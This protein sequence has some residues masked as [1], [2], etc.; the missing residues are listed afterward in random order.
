MLT[1]VK[2]FLRWLMAPALYA[3]WIGTV[4]LTIFKRVEW[5][6][7]LLIAMIPQPNVWYTLREYPLGNNFIDLLVFAILLGI[8]FQGKGFGRSR[9]GPVIIAFI[10]VSY[11]SLWNA[12]FNFSLPIPITTANTLFPD[13]KNYAEM[14]L[15]YFLVFNVLKDEDQHKLVVVMMSVVI[16][17]IS[18]RS[19]RNFSGGASFDYEKR[20]GGPFEAVGLGSNHFGAFIAYYC[21]L[22][23]G[24]FFFDKDYRRR[25]LFMT[26]YLFGLHPL[27]FAYSRGAYLGALGALAFMG[28]FTKRSLL[29]VVAVVVI[30]WQT[31]LPASVVD[32]ITMTES[33]SGQLDESAASRLYVWEHAYELFHDNPIFGIGFGGFGFTMPEGGLTDTHNFYMK[34]LSEQG[35]IGFIMLTIVLL[36][37]LSSGWRLLRIGSTPFYKGLGFGFVGCVIACIIANVFGDRWSYFALGGYLWIFWGIVDRGILNSQ[38]NSIVKEQPPVPQ[39][40]EAAF[41][42]P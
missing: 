28:V 26:T 2:D 34:T 20:V 38:K 17:L 9:S 7:F 21:T 30:G 19:Y 37:A 36:M 13:W 29:I 39:Q 16:L 22:F 25:L 14:I 3:G 8:I 5:G 12:S 10:V 32:R 31:L 6:L 24:L 11:L 15:L 35:V 23:L 33:A 18:I 41:T 42:N 40:T 27:F 1:A 4:L